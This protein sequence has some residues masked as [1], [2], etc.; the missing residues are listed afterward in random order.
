MKL[1]FSPG[2]CSLAIHIALYEAGLAF[3]TERVDLKTKKTNSGADFTQINPKGYVPALEL[4]DKAILTECTAIALYVADR[5]PAK[6]IAP[7]AGTMDYFRCIEWMNYIA[8]EMHKQLG[9]L[10]NPILSDEVR[11]IGRDNAGRRIGLV[12]KHLATNAY[13]MGSAYSVADAYCFTVLRW[14]PYVKIDLNPFTNVVG[15]LNRIVARP[16]VQAA[17]KAEGLLKK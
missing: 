9:S 7:K 2:A 13:L 16:A 17:F 11:Q 3:D 4:D 15:Y 5:A 6:A 12:D 14:A 10:F 1:Y 8:T